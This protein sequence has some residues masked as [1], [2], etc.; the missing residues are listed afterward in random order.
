MVLKGK[1]KEREYLGDIF[2]VW[3]V[4]F[5]STVCGYLECFGLT[6]EGLFRVNGNSKTLERLR[7]EY[8]KGSAVDLRA[9]GADVASVAGLLKLFLRELP[10]PLVPL[11]T[12]QALLKEWN[13]LLH[14]R[15]PFTASDSPC[16]AP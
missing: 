13:K 3:M 8:E 9:L 16:E 10:D 5:L 4:S 6:T 1:K 2:S 11:A 15:A 7:H 12:H 14:F